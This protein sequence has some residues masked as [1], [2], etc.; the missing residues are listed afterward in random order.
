MF[1]RF[2]RIPERDG[3]TDGQTDEYTDGLQNCYI[4]IAIKTKTKIIDKSQNCCSYLKILKY[5]VY[6]ICVVKKDACM[7]ILV[8]PN[9]G[10]TFA[11]LHSYATSLNCVYALC[12][13]VC[14]ASISNLI[15]LGRIHDNS[16]PVY[17]IQ[18][19][20]VPFPRNSFPRGAFPRSSL[21][22]RPLRRRA[23]RSAP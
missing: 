23:A 11:P 17:F 14:F 16:A 20:W 9:T 1:S 15:D 22:R 2:H 10:S 4:R 18:T 7:I 6:T 19:G 8:P 3:Q 21:P 5:S 12:S 13:V